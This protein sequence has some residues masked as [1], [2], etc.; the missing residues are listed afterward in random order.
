MIRFK[1]YIFG[2]FET[3]IFIFTDHSKHT[4]FDGGFMSPGIRVGEGW[5][6]GIYRLVLIDFKFVKC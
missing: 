6:R 5:G 3:L 1:F 2:L 4:I